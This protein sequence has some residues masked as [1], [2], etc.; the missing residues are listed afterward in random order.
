M[1]PTLPF[2]DLMKLSAALPIL[3]LALAR[4][5]WRLVIPGPVNDADKQGWQTTLAYATHYIF[6]ICFF[7]I[8]NRTLRPDL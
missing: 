7:H 4:M 3:M 2:N 5:V 6:Y 8:C 1:A